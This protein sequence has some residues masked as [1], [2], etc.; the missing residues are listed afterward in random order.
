LAATGETIATQR[1]ATQRNAKRGVRA[2]ELHL[3]PLELIARLAALVPPAKPIWVAQKQIV[4]IGL[5]GLLAFTQV[6][7]TP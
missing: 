5:F 4:K 3:T 6:A 2:D 1:N 7:H